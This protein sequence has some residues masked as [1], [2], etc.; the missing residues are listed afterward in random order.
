MM[1]NSKHKFDLQFLVILLEILKPSNSI[2]N[3]IILSHLKISR[4]S[5]HATSSDFLGWCV[6]DLAMFLIKKRRRKEEGEKKEKERKK[7]RERIMEK[8]W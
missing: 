8:Y 2:S 3:F 4:L 1:E 6:T 7:E 5:L